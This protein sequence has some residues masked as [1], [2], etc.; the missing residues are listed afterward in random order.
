MLAQFGHDHTFEFRSALRRLLRHWPRPTLSHA[1]NR[2]LDALFGECVF[3]LIRKPLV[4]GLPLAHHRGEILA[5]R[6]KFL[7]V[8]PVNLFSGAWSLQD[9]SAVAAV[10]AEAANIIAIARHFIATALP[11]SQACPKK[12]AGARPALELLMVGRPA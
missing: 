11:V 9:S 7:S 5:V 10:T 3:G 1:A 8:S 4:N 2:V 12:E 6:H